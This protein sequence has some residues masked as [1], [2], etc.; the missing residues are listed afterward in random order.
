VICNGPSGSARLFDK[1]CLGVLEIVKIACA[2]PEAGSQQIK[3]QTAIVK[4]RIRARNGD[5]A[6]ISYYLKNSLGSGACFFCSASLIRKT[7]GKN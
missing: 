7:K 5:R 4:A 3:Q 2:A 1:P 6:Y